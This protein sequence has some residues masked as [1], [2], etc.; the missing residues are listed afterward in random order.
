MTKLEAQYKALQHSYEEQG[1]RARRELEDMRWQ[2]RV[3]RTAA[4]VE[5]VGIVALVIRGIA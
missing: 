2:M 3:W 5:A 4:C 1:R